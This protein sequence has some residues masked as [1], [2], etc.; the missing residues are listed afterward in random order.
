[1]RQ[2]AGGKFPMVGKGTNVKSMAYVEN[3]AAFIE[4]NLNNPPGEHLFNY[5]DKP[6]FDMN[7]LV[8]EVRRVLGKSGGL[9]HWPYWMGLAGGLC[10][11]VLA[12]MLHKKLPVSAI[13]V[14][15]FCANTMFA[16]VNIKMTDFKPPV[17]LAEG[18]ERTI[19]YEFIDKTV[20]T[21]QVFYTE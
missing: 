1:L 16:S 11:D 8:S 14:K 3:I 4:Y 17:S 6:D 7:T 18:L 21:D 19:K 2:I 12:K 10:F 15:K 20:E 13:R 9:V 5:I